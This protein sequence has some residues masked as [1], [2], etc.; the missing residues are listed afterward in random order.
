MKRLIGTWNVMRIIRLLV[1]LVAI[2][3]AIVLHEWPLALTGG[4]LLLMAVANAGCC[5]A[6]ACG[7]PSWKQRSS[8]SEK[9]NERQHD[10]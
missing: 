8:S 9:P 1:G 7:I 6:G 4:F 3:Q 2:W 5:G 10:A